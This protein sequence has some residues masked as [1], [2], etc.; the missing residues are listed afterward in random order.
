MNFN[1]ITKIC[2]LESGWIVIILIKND[3]KETIFGG[4]GEYE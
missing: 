2:S 1:R 4:G 3:T